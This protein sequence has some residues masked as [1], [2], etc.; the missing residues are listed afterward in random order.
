MPR[1]RLRLPHPTATNSEERPT[2][3]S[4]EDPRL[5]L[6]IGDIIIIATDDVR[7]IVTSSEM[8]RDADGTLRPAVYSVERV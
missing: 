2:V 6:Q 1:H 7:Y 3:W 4:D 5:G 8:Q